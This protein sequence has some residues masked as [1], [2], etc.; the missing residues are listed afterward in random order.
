MMAVVGWVVSGG[1]AMRSRSLSRHGKEAAVTQLGPAALLTCTL[2]SIQ[3]TYIRERK[4]T[5]HTYIIGPLKFSSDYPPET[6]R[7]QNVARAPLMGRL[8]LKK[9]V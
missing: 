4:H 7:L 3:C 6:F 1:E 5:H 2:Y 9:H 8:Y